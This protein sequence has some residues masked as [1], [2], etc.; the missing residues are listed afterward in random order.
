MLSTLCIHLGLVLNIWIIDKLSCW[1]TSD[2]FLDENSGMADPK[3]NVY[4]IYEYYLLILCIELSLAIL[5]PNYFKNNLI[6]FIH[7]RRHLYMLLD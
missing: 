7:F 6:P 2:T 5:H 1:R 3:T 4:V